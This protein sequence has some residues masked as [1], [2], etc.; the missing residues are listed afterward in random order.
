MCKRRA[1]R[2]LSVSEWVCV[3]SK[4][5]QIEEAANQKKKKSEKEE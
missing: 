5:T 2:L 1:E 4:P 3:Q